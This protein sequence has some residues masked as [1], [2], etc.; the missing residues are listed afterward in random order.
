MKT[1]TNKSGIKQLREW[2]KAFIRFQMSP[3][4]IS[5]PIAHR[6]SRP[7]ILGAESERER[8]PYSRDTD[9]MIR[10]TANCYSDV[11]VR[12]AASFCVSADSGAQ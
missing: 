4:W 3:R 12:H 2:F 7:V 10:I 11:A 5:D 1:T 6:A 8:N 9:G